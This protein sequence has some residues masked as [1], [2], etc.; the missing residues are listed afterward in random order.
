M[1]SFSIGSGYSAVS[2][3]HG[4]LYASGNTNQTDTIWCL[5]STTGREIWRHSYP[6][7][8]NPRQERFGPAASPFVEEGRVYTL[9]LEG[10]LFC[11]DPDSGKVLWSK[12]VAREV[13]ARAPQWGFSGS[14]LIS[15]DLLILNVGSAGTAIEKASGRIA[16]TSGN[17]PSGYASPVAFNFDGRRQVAIFGADALICVN[18]TDGKELWRQPWETE[19]GI[20][21][22]D[23]V[24]SWDKAFIS[25]NY[26]K[27]CGLVQFGAGK[28]RLVWQNHN[29]HAHIT[30]TLVQAMW[31]GRSRCQPLL[32][33]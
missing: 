4:K 15:G 8:T 31:N 18:P 20:N 22:A 3:S 9:S 24:V 13:G 7:R 6:C 28:P 16:W 14:P 25:S 1:W 21:V 27:G 2:I 5:E 12:Q 23:P 26:G 33:S 30:S 19:Y 10:E 32:R 11:F 29:L 17:S